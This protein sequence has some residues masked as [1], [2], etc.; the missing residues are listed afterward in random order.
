[1]ST[2]TRRWVRDNAWAYL[3]IAPQI[4]GLLVFV[5]GPVIFAFVISFMKWDIGSTPEWVGLTNYSKQVSDP[6]FWKVLKNTSV[7][8]LL[9]IPL[10]VI[11][12]LALALMLNQ[13]LKGKTLLRAA[14][15]IPVVT[16]SVAVALVWTWLYNPSYGLINS[17]LMSLGIEGP[18]WLSDMKWA[19][20]SIVIMT[21]WQGVGY[22]MILFLAG[23]QGV[24]SQ[25]HEAAKMDGAGSWQRFWRI[26]IPMISPT[27]FFVVIMLLIGSMQV[28]SEPY[29]MTR[30]GPAD[31]TNVLVLHIYNTAFQFFRMGEASAI[32]FI[33]FVIIL[34]VTLI[35]FKFSKWVNYDV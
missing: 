3:F 31:A 16:S 22:N 35:Q 23:L 32:S 12:A 24:P 9:N 29:M 14:Y 11:G 4:L 27:T 5:I 13:N 26:T 10:T 19:L 25:L 1:M 8:A 20:P 2:W 33:L 34:I 28:F 6:I 17:V 15:F 30:G 7:F 21:V 18:G